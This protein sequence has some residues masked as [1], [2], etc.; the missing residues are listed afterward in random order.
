VLAGPLFV[1]VV[2]VQI[3]T[4]EGFD[5]SRHPISLLSV[6]DLG[7]IQMA[8]FVIAGISWP[9]VSPPPF[10]VA[11]APGGGRPGDP[12]CSASTASASSPAAC[13]LLIPRWASPRA[14]RMASRP[15]SVGTGLCTHSRHLELIGPLPEGVGAADGPENATTVLLF[16][17]G[18]QALRDSLSE[19]RD[20]LASAV[21]VWVAYPK[22]NRADIN[23]DTVWPILGEYRMNPV[24][25]VAID[26]V[27]SAM[28]FRA[29]R[30]GEALIGPFSLLADLGRAPLWALRA[31][32]AAAN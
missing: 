8:N 22:G 31:S 30:D 16:V 29:P 32:G 26:E 28:R 3:L 17:D 15:R 18:A 24:S 13:S 20:G 9:S 1:I 25:Q 14:R 23:R 21:N 12:V 2:A 10:G 5:L 6:G 7:W 27:W 4:R 19:H 11:S